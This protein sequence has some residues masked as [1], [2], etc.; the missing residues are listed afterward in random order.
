MAFN[1]NLKLGKEPFSMNVKLKKT[2]RRLPG[3]LNQCNA[4]AKNL[5]LPSVINN[6]D[7]FGYHVIFRIGL[8]VLIIYL[9]NKAVILFVERK[10]ERV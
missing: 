2:S 1:Y 9:F 7:Q 3:G 10:C 5:S 6:G 4:G 8:N